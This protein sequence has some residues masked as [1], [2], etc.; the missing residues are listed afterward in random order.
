MPS[1]EQREA[2]GGEKVVA[3]QWRL[4]GEPDELWTSCRREQA[5]RVAGDPEWETRALIPQS[6]APV[7]GEAMVAVAY[8][9]CEDFIE[10]HG[11]GYLNELDDGQW[12]EML[13]AALTAALGKG[14][15]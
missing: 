12:N 6:S 7:V 14:E 13:H 8:R 3:W 4:V 15:G 1:N 5:E 2:I 9:V 11:D 10:K